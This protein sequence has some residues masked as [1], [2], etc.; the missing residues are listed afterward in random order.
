M[1]PEA[2]ERYALLIPALNEAETLGALLRQVP[3]DLFE[4]IIVVDNGSTDGTSQV[5]AGA[6]VCVVIEPR[7]GYGR[8]CQAGIRSLRPEITAVAFMD[9]DLSD[10]PSDLAR[11]VRAFEEGGCDL[12]VGS[13]VL[14]GSE[15]GSLTSLQRFGN[16]LSTRLIR[17]L[18]GASFTD[19]GPMRI[20]R[21]EVLERLQLQD[22]DYGWNVEM[23]AKAARL[24]LPAGEIA[25]KYR[26][27]AGGKSKIS[28]TLAGSVAAGWK[29]LWTIYRCWR[30]DARSWEKARL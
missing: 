17:W 22:Y 3:P 10:D 15:P 1:P 8:A 24:R 30:D 4:Q 28:G 2:Q 21:R 20:V 16:W 25:V 7:R 26:R 19:L 5:A 12:L 13:R 23:Q 6:G 14:G 29:I 27:R 9:A 11:L 18:W